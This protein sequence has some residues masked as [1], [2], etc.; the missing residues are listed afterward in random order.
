MQLQRPSLEIPI[1][2]Q[3]QPR[4]LHPI[5]SPQSQ[6]WTHTRCTGGQPFPNLCPAE[7]A[8][9]WPVCA[10]PESALTSR[11]PRPT[12]P[13]LTVSSSFSWCLTSS[14]AQH[15]PEAGLPTGSTNEWIHWLTI[16]E[17]KVVFFLMTSASQPQQQGF[18]LGTYFSHRC[19]DHILYLLFLD[20]LE[21]FL[22]LSSQFLLTPIP[23]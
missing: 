15:L 7:P 8:R 13:W 5:S 19:R 22:T 17:T 4:L 18:F 14:E 6:P 11:R 10:V 21:F 20:S 1:L 23:C 2:W 9:N 12:S 16:Q 3:S